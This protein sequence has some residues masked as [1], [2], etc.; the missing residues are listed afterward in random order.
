MS[1]KMTNEE[2]IRILKLEEIG[3]YTS[4]TKD[5]WDEAH[6]MAREALRDKREKG[7]WKREDTVLERID[8]TK[9]KIEGDYVICSVC[10]RKYTDYVRGYEWEVTNEQ[11]NFCPHC[12]ADMREN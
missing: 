12:G 9:G 10:K 3:A 2:A 8:G 6:Y 5:E 1:D 4:Y 11:P 7:E